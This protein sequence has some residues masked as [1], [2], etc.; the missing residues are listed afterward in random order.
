MSTEAQA[1]PDPSQ[2]FAMKLIQTL[3]NGA[4]C[5]MISIGHRTGLFDTLATLYPE[6]VSSQTLAQKTNLNERY[7]REWLGGMVVGGII[8][9]D[10]ES[11]TYRFPQEHAAF[12]TRAVGIKNMCVFSEWFPILG[13]YEDNILECFKNGGG[14]PTKAYERLHE[15]IAE[16]SRLTVTM[17]QSTI[18]PGLPGVLDKLKQG[19]NVLEIGCGR[20]LVTLDLAKHFPNCTFRGYDILDNLIADAN[21]EAASSG[22]T[23]VSFHVQD[24][25]QMED[26][27]KHDIVIGFDAMHDLAE[28]ADALKCVY[29]A[30][31]DDGI[32]AMLDVNASSD[33][34][35][36][37]SHILGPAIYT[38]SSYHCVS[39]SLA[40]GGKGLGAAWGTE[41]ALK[42]IKEAGFSKT[43]NIQFPHDALSCWFVNRK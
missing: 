12:M 35:K 23:N 31:K 16:R 28:P 9:Y 6:Y 14:I 2:M 24:V 32:Y 7:V 11:K 13:S 30:L 10:S 3:N 18:L 21:A 17:L 41:L 26:V 39:V 36:N 38:A 22:L 34:E 19:C 15:V 43:E 4:L 27:N 29:R 37:K 20:G 1:M 8:E 25:S 40:D 42:M 33:L 5:L